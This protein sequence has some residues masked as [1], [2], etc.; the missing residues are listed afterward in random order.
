MAEGVKI[1]LT[2]LS[3]K[4]KTSVLLRVIEMLEEEEK[5][6]GGIVSESVSEGGEVQ[7]IDLIDWTTKDKRLLVH[8]TEKIG[9]EIKIDGVEY[10]LDMNTLEL[11][12]KR[13]I[14]TALNNADIVVIDEVGQVAAM[15]EEFGKV[16]KD[17]LDMEKDILITLHKKSRELLLQEIRR[18]DDVRLLEVTRINIGLLPYKIMSLLKRKRYQ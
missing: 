17:A 12:A 16:V 15:S 10:F 5:I 3:Q 9:E 8:K 6:I 2:G 11:F 18:R 4:R 1:G 7:S 14:K 13:A